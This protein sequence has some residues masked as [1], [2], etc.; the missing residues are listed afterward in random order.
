MHDLDVNDDEDL[1]DLSNEAGL[2]RESSLQELV[3]GA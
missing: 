3:V 2:D 1:G